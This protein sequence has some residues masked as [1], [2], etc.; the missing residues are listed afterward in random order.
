MIG[1]LPLLAEISD[2]EPSVLKLW[3]VAAVLSAASLLLGLWR[4][5][6]A[7]IPAAFAVIWAVVVWSE[8]HDAIMSKAIQEE[9]GTT[10]IA[11]AYVAILLP[12]AFIVLAL[13]RNRVKAA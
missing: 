2:K 8:V 13:F 10:Y 6:L 5:W 9:L 1:L 12:L 3:L 4:R 7:L 11:Q